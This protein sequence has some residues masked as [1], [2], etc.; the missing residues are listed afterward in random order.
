MKHTTENVEFQSGGETVRGWFLTPPG[1]VEEPGPGVVFCAG[2]T[3]TKYAAFYVPYVDHLVDAGYSVLMIDYRG[4]GD[5]DGER[6]VIDPASQ[7]EDIRSGLTYL[8]ERPEVDADRC[9]IL[10]MS[11]GGGNVVRAASLDDRV[12]C[13]IAI[14]AVGDGGL[15]LR[16][17]RRE[18]EWYE[19]LD[20]I[21]DDR[22]RRVAGAPPEL[23]SPVEDIM[24]QTPERRQTTVKGAVPAGMVSTTT[25]LWCA[26]EIRNYKPYLE[27]ARISPAG[28]LL[29][30]VEEDAVVPA[31]HS[32]LIYEHAV[33]PKRL[34]LMEGR[35]HYGTYLGKFDRI[36]PEIA[37]W[38][39]THLHERKA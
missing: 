4:W 29:F 7:V 28:L 3:G 21:A 6:G 18:Y 5:S 35:E 36:W 32:R 24:I 20:R 26:E 19:L 31:E 17:M 23:V 33:E 38:L 9:G 22:R 34:V 39:E 10:G 11:F 12:R 37:S 15:W 27:A 1:T 30:A 14:S 16:Q 8:G 13:C 2:F 25:P